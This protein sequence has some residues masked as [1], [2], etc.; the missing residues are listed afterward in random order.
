MAYFD[1]LKT[2]KE[3]L[4][5]R[6]G[7]LKSESSFQDLEEEIP[8]LDMAEKRTRPGHSSEEHWGANDVI[9]KQG[10]EFK[11]ENIPIRCVEEVRTCILMGL[12]PIQ[13]SGIAVNTN[14]ILPSSLTEDQED[15]DDIPLSQPI[16][17]K[18][19]KT[20]NSPTGDKKRLFLDRML[21]GVQVKSRFD[22]RRFKTIKIETHDLTE[23]DVSDIL[24]EGKFSTDDEFLRLSIK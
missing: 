6:P 4:G 20:D 10:D 15:I 16:K 19:R 13:A 21:H 2:A 22:K 8:H 14:F 12:G 11:R 24:N 3:I 23:G 7:F 18:K 1:K 5:K 9:S 17:E